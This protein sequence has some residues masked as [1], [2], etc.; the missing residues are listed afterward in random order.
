[1]TDKDAAA[2]KLREVNSILDRA[3]AAHIVHPRNAD[4]H[5]SRLARFVQK[6][7]EAAN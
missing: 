5:K 2:T 3:A 6:L 1:M 4:R 7:G